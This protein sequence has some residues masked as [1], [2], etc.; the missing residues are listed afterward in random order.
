MEA[1]VLGE[2]VLGDAGVLALEVGQD[3]AE[4]GAVG[5]DL[6]L[7]GGVLAQDRGELHGD[8]HRYTD[9]LVGSGGNAA[10][11]FVVDQ[12]GDGRR[13]AAH[14]AIGVPADLHF[15]EVHVQGVVQEQPADQR[16]ALPV[17][18]LIASVAW[19][20]PITPGRTPN[21][22]PS[23]QLGTVPGGGGEGKRQR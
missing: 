7:A 15:L 19:I 2:H 20:E 23:A 16:L 10:E 17:I 9:S 4:R 13:L 14:R 8:G 3:V 1:A 21:T 11:R 18:S 5:T 22:P 12:L 6:R